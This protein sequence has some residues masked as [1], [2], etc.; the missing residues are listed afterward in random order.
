MEFGKLRKEGSSI[1]N[2]ELNTNIIKHAYGNEIKVEIKKELTISN[3]KIK[4][5]N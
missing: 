5:K 1:E 3:K 4:L 2:N